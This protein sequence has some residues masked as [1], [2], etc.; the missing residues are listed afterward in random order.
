MDKKM[1]FF[2]GGQAGK[3]S[4]G[5]LM[6]DVSYIPDAHKS[7]LNGLIGDKC[8]RKISFVFKTGT[9]QAERDREKKP[10]D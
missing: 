5:P 9:R 2:A 8:S 10:L 1:S 3:F 7:N 4:N 6:S